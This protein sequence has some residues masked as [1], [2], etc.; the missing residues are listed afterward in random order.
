[1]IKELSGAR[2]VAGAL[3]QAASD[4]EA[5]GGAESAQGNA[6]GWIRLEVMMEEYL[7][8][9]EVGCVWGGGGYI[10]CVYT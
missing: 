2:V 10:V 6:G 9:A 4:D 7:D 5:E 1:M 3:E 8:G